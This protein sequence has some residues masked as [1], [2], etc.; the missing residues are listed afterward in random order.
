MSLAERTVKLPMFLGAEKNLSY[1][2]Y[3]MATTYTEQHPD[4]T[5]QYIVTVE[6]VGITKDTDG[7]PMRVFVLRLERE[8]S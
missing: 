1:E 2:M 6:L 5:G 7:W 3:V 4:P 8:I